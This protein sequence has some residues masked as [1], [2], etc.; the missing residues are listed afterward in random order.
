MTYYQI[1][2]QLMLYSTRH[3]ILALSIAKSYEV[4]A[5]KYQLGLIVV[6]S[7]FKKA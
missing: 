1:T 7:H 4:K 6:L 3:V 2:G 5:G